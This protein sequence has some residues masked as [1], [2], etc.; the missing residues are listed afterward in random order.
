VTPGAGTPLWRDRS[1]AVFLAAQTLSAAGDSFAL[2]A[3]PLLVLRATAVCLLLGLAA[4]A[5]PI[6]QAT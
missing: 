2:I 4:V 1:F 6:R 3:L 5:S